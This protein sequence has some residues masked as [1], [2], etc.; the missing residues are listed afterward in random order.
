MEKSYLDPNE[1]LQKQWQLAAEVRSSGWKPDFVIGLWRGG[2]SVA[3]SV[4]EF[5]RAT[6]WDVQ[7]YP[8]KC[9]SY[10]GIGRNEGEVVFSFAEEIFALF[11][12][13][14]KVLF[15][16]D[17]FDTGKTAVAVLEKA[18]SCG[19][20]AKIACVYYKSVKNKTGIKPDFFVKDPGSQ[21]LVFPHEM[22]GLSSHELVQKDTF[23]ASLAKRF[24]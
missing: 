20:E 3:V 24:A 10:T 22:E 17:V 1:Y 6:G 5:L 8:L 12:K 21:W 9:S 16:D 13:G 4:H 19:A 11:K 15:V 14:A 2:A 7:H 23:L 18:Q